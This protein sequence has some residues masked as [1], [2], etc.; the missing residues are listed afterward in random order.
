MAFSDPQSV[1]INGATSSLP[2]RSGPNQTN[3]QVNGSFANADDTL[4]LGIGHQTA[5][6]TQRVR[7]TVRIDQAKVV[8]NPIDSSVDQDSA[9]V[10]VVID[11]PGYGFT[12]ADIQYLVAALAGY[13]TT[14]NVAKLYGREA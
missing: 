2:R 12:V 9:A 13:L 5:S 11:R 6:G 4:K 8:T 14:A 3:N 7:S 1:T 10:Y